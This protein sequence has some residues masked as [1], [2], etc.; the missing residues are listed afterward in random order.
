MHDRVTEAYHEL[1]NGIILRAVTDYRN[2][3]VGVGYGHK[4]PKTVVIECERFFRSYYFT[5]LTKISGEYLIEKIR[6]EVQDEGH[7]NSTDT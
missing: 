1:A 4:T 2:A 5:L 6:K 7:V 3:L